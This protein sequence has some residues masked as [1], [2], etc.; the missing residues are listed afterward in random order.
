MRTWFKSL[1]GPATD[2]EVW[3]GLLPKKSAG[4]RTVGTYPS[5]FR[6]FIKL[7][8][9]AFREWD[10]EFASL[11]DTA[12]KGQSCEAGVFARAAFAAVEKSKGKEAGQI[13]WDI[14]SFYEH[15]MPRQLQKAILKQQILLEAATLALWGHIA[16]RR[17]VLRGL[18]HKKQ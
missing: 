2:F 14:A 17:L 3:L 4:Y 9:V 10:A 1:L 13:L 5:M 7:V 12:V 8:A 15:V 18:R 11:M 6:M 16:P